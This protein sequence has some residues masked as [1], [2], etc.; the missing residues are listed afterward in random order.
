MRGYFLLAT[1]VLLSACATP[2]YAF[3]SALNGPPLS[4]A[5]TVAVAPAV[6]YVDEP[7]PKIFGEE[8]SRFVSEGVLTGAPIRDV[9]W[10]FDGTRRIWDAAVVQSR[11]VKVPILALGQYS[12]TGD[13]VVLSYRLVN[14][15]GYVLT[16]A[17]DLISNPEDKPLVARRLGERLAANLR[18]IAEKAGGRP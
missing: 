3:Q 12:V 10:R 8:I 6:E 4:I 18:V 9:A 15:S 14:E 16:A 5:W 11:K 7:R 17:T 1:T 2:Y 13:G